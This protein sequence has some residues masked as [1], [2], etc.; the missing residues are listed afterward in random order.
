MKRK[1]NGHPA[2]ARGPEN[3]TAEGRF[4][5]GTSG[6]EAF[7]GLYRS[8]HHGKDAAIRADTRKCFVENG[9][10]P[11]SMTDPSTLTHEEARMLLESA[12]AKTRK[13]IDDPR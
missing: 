5:P 4:A 7:T 9:L 6:A 11:D 2:A 12:R 1:L 8:A 10:D 3:R 13:L